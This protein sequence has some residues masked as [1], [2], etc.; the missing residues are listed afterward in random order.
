MTI[1][2]SSTLPTPMELSTPTDIKALKAARK[3]TY[4]RWG[5][6]L[7]KLAGYGVLGIILFFT[8]LTFTGLPSVEELENPKS[9]TASLAFAADGQVIGRFF[10]QNRVP[11]SYDQ[12][13]PYLVDAL[14]ATEDER[15]LQH[16]GIDFRAVGRA[17]YR[18]LILG[19]ESGGGGST[20]T[21]QLAKLMFTEKPSNNVV[22]RIMQKFK[23]W[24]IA[25]KLEASYTKEEI[26]A[27]YLNKFNFIN[28]A[29]GIKAAA[30]NYFG[31][32]QDSLK[33][34]E[35]ALLVGMLKNPN[36]YNPVRKPEV[37]KERRNVVLYQML[38]NRKLSKSEFDSLKRLE[39]DM[40]RFR[41][42]KH[43]E[44]LAPYF[45]K[46]LA[47]YVQ[48]EIIAKN[49]L[50]NSDGKLYN[51]WTDG[52]KIY[53]T[54][55]MR[56]Q[57]H[58][59]ESMLEHMPKIQKRF[60]SVWHNRDP[61]QYKDPSKEPE[62]M[63]YEMNARSRVMKAK[64]R[65]SDRYQT[66]HEKLFSPSVQEI[67]D[68]FGGYQLRDVDMD[69]MM[70]AN[71]NKNYIAALLKEKQISNKLADTY[72]KIMD[73]K[74]WPT[75]A[76]KWEKLQNAV[77]KDFNK[78][79]KMRIFTWDAK[80][81]YE[82][83]TTISPYDSI[84]YLSMFLQLGSVAID[85]TTGFVKG[86]VGGINHKYF[87]Y[88]HVTSDRQVG[89]TFK[90]FVYATAINMLGISPCQRV[91]DV[92]WT[93]HQGEGGF[94]LLEDWTPHN[95]DESYTGNSYTLFEA[96][97]KSKNTVSVYLMKQLG[98]VE[99]V[100]NLVNNMGLDKYAIKRI[101]PKGRD[102]DTIFRVPR[103]PSICLGA[104]DLKVLELTGAY[105]TFANNG[106]WN[107]PIFITEIRDK[108]G[109]TIYTELGDERTAL[110]PGP[111]YVMVEM[112]RAVADEASGF[113]SLKS[114]IGGKT[115]TTNDYV[116]GWYVGITP[117]L[118]VGTWVGGDERWIRFLSS[119]DG[120]GGQMAR[121]YFARLMRS[122]ENDP[123]VGLDTTVTF[124]RPPGDLGITYD[125][126]TYRRGDSGNNRENKTPPAPR[127]ENFGADPF[128][129]GQ[130]P[131]PPSNNR[132]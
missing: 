77:E 87:Q 65:G 74:A 55:D 107:K 13:S 116:D 105:S 122:L 131:K 94:G 47:K 73:S 31:K 9:N 80:N 10:H 69:R 64:V 48:E 115:G 60:F 129:A 3:P 30:E 57:Q 20:I 75:V 52:L 93:I 11:V 50:R 62:E 56:V 18:T 59:E 5:R 49:K 2:V 113:G 40:S 71:T 108:Q 28:D 128:T 132:R 25:V 124:L 46:E 117:R 53:T 121:P 127:N 96:L 119:R 99:P 27:L 84:K 102:I 89:S 101:D 29:Y 7:W 41:R 70:V 58:M 82:K 38:V 98:D 45:R 78:P 54:I 83:D 26:I 1:Q 68:L 12:L 118:A 104:C 125:C 106:V 33:V 6:H 67:S 37:A 109:K 32:S 8:F 44:G 43:Y 24:I 81:N 66:M 61:W 88:D 63:A 111:N 42:E 4:E 126:W 72:Q 91:N 90:P 35:A 36:K 17:F 123:K 85:P 120:I 34:E 95:V 76:A 23:E 130:A 15:Y 51:V 21:Q 14:I 103:Q 16:P 92:A 97:Q 19:D 86:W 79:V 114:D 112:L 22:S 39:I 110:N 100:R